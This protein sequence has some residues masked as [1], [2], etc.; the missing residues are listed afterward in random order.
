MAC[1]RCYR[2]EFALLLLLGVVPGFFT[3]APASEKAPSAP[4]TDIGAASSASSNH[5][6]ALLFDLLGDEKNVSKLL[7]IKRERAELKEVVKAI[8]HAA[9]EAH[10]QLEKFGKKDRSLNLKDMGLPGAETAAR[11]SISKAKAKELLTDKGQ[12]FELK[13]LLSQNE[14]LTY[15]QHLASTAAQRESNPQRQQFL[16]NLARELDQ[17]RRRVV[18]ILGAHYTWA[19]DTK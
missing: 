4:Q 12:D 1:S 16:Q 17:L 6:Y 8:S 9:G 10:K 7:I 13:L 14:A 11:E 2:K 18:D 15:G 19:A 3:A 5:G